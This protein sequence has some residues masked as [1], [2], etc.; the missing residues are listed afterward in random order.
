MRLLDRYLLRDLLVPFFYILFGL[1]I[2]WI[3]F[4]LFS[5]LSD[6]QKRHLL[7]IDIAEYYFYKVPELLSVVLPVNLLLA[8]LYALTNHARHNELTAMRAAGVSLMRVSLPY[9]AVG[10]IL[11]LLVMVLNEWWLPRSA[12][13][14]EAIFNQY[15]TNAHQT[16]RGDW[17]LDCG[18][19][20]T[21]EKRTWMMEAFNRS[22]ADIVRPHIE[23]IL[24]DGTR[25]EVY[26]DAGGWVDQH[27]VFTN[28][29]EFVYPP[30]KGTFPLLSNYTERVMTAFHELPEEIRIQIKLAKI[31]DIREARNAHLSIRDIMLYRKLHPEDIEK[32]TLLH[33]RLAAPWTCLVVVLIALPFGAASG[34]RNV[35]VGVASSVVFCFGYFVFQQLSLV[36]G[37]SG[38]IPGWLAGWL[39]NLVFSAVGIFYS[40]RIR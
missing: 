1:F 13:R 19:T 16:A 4:D 36:L 35:F 7:A 5:E 34:R 10:L 9:F 30:V 38:R 24:P 23:W 37:F 6:F 15:N 21:R 2:F 27:W 33:G 22:T 3:A 39:P 31:A 32:N 14:T 20:N 26:A 12:E 17:E 29:Q 40:L 8:L 25:H 11:S 28:V 18:F